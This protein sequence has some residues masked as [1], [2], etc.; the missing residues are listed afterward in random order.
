MPF[1][2]DSWL[3]ADVIKRNRLQALMDEH[4]WTKEEVA[5]KLITVF[6]RLADLMRLQFAPKFDMQHGSLELIEAT[7]AF[8]SAYVEFFGLDDVVTCKL[9]QMRHGALIG[10]DFGSWL[11][12]CCAKA[13][14]KHRQAKR[15]RFF[16]W[17][18]FLSEFEVDISFSF[19]LLTHH[20]D[21]Y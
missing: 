5:P 6:V 9:H 7:E 11:N 20:F 17:D 15:V 21:I 18:L 13:E 12:Q 1:I 19:P 2:L 16:K 3:T 8:S 10:I 4:G 14:A